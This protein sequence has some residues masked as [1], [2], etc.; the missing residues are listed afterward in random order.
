[1]AVDISSERARPAGSDAEA[2]PGPFR[3]R[4]LFEAAFGG[5]L[6]GL[7][8]A[9]VDLSLVRI[10]PN[11]RRLASLIAAALAFYPLAAL[12]GGVCVGLLATTRK[13][14]GRPITAE[15]VFLLL[16]GISLALLGVAYLLFRVRDPSGFS[17][18]ALA[19]GGVLCVAAGASFVTRRWYHGTLRPA[20][21]LALGTIWFVTLGTAFAFSRPGPSRVSRNGKLENLVILI[22]A[23]TLRADALGAYGNPAV[24]TPNLDALAADGALFLHAQS[25][26]SWT[27]P[28]HASMLTG[29]TV[30]Q[31]GA[32]GKSFAMN[33]S[34]ATIA[35]RFQA[36]GFRTEAI[37]SA[38]LTSS[39]FFERGFDSFDDFMAS[40]FRWFS[41]AAFA[42][43][44]SRLRPG[45]DVPIE[46]RAG[47]VVD[48]ALPRLHESG[49]LFL[50]V[51]FFDAHTDYSPPPRFRDS[52]PARIPAPFDGSFMPLVTVNRG[53]LPPPSPAELSVLRKLY[54]GEV[55]YLDAQ[56][57]RL[58]RE[59]EKA[60]L[61]GRTSIVFTADHGEAFAE[62]GLFLHTTVF[63]EVVHV[64]LIVWAPGRIRPGSRV[65]A[66]VRGMDVAP[67]LAELGGIRWTG[68]GDAV[69]VLPLLGEE[70]RFS[71]PARS[72]SDI[73]VMYGQPG[74]RTSSLLVWPWKLI[75]RPS[76]QR[77]NLFN[78]DRDPGET[79]DVASTERRLADQL[80]E[81]LSSGETPYK[82]DRRRSLDAQTI[83][84]LRSLGYIN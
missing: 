40:P 59:I 42:R 38:F 30:P 39:K 4:S 83:R 19:T 73:Q 84:Q 70:E 44:L 22:T 28:S 56:I 21:R 58:R 57:G 17:W 62:H 15:S 60:G 79:R 80:V 37:T 1:M 46:K 71:R 74:E 69:S 61:A 14:S 12:L 34:A 51:H 5:W 77:I 78:L 8:F 66:I 49:S 45:L 7:L 43:K 25:A 20:V 3:L 18:Q 6:S 65:E 81:I 29:L 27:L 67:T 16:S 55:S 32:D 10:H 75:Y 24:R 31:H 48:E 11:G 54:D 52:L 47:D 9:A 64:P 41:A 76:D 13:K 2:P 63:E 26:S 53:Q 36:R 82:L 72:D 33:E 35:E 50:W 23:D 68:S